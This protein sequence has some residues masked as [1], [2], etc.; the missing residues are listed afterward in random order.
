MLI[1]QRGARP[2]D[3]P[4]YFSVVLNPVLHSITVVDYPCP[5]V[6]Q[7]IIHSTQLRERCARRVAGIAASIAPPLVGPDCGFT[8]QNNDLSN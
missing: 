2:R 7:V 8:S 4:R 6:A 1:V 3:T 5:S